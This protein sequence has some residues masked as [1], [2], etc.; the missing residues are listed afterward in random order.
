[1]RRGG[2]LIV[3]ARLPER[4]DDEG[5]EGCHVSGG[6]VKLGVVYGRG[7]GDAEVRCYRLEGAGLGGGK[8]LVLGSGGDLDGGAYP[9]LPG[10]RREG[11]EGALE[12][13]RE[14]RVEAVEAGGGPEIG[15]A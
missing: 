1:M 3:Q 14:I 11:L 5:V 8:V 15:R 12:P 13:V 6:G 10:E 2:H 7:D 9:F 4:P